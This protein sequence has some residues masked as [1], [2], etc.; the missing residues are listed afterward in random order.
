MH[1]HPPPGFPIRTLPIMRALTALSLHPN[2]PSL[3]PLAL[4][5]L[6][7]ETFVHHTPVTEPAS[8]TR[9]L[10]EVLDGKVDVDE[11]L[12]KANSDEVKARLAANTDEAFDDGAF[13]LPW[14]V[15][16][17]GEGRKESFWGCDRLG[18]VAEFLGLPRPGGDG[19]KAML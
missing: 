3:L 1:E 8:L 14:M 6:Y 18:M 2:S 11:I 16:E 10:H 17:D 19:L 4:D 13:G 9:I 5:A 15:C 12:S 7:N